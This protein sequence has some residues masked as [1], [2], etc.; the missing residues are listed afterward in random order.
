MTIYEYIGYTKQDIEQIILNLPR[1]YIT[2]KILK[3]SGKMRRIDAPQNPLKNIQKEIL[4][5]VLYLYK[6]HP[7]AHGFVKDKSP[8]TNA[9]AHVGRKYVLSIDI[10]NF[11]NSISEQTVQ[12]CLIW[13]FKQQTKFTWNID[14]CSIFAKLLCYNGGLPQGSPASPVMSNLVCLALDK[15]LAALAAAN[16][17]TITRYADDITLSSNDE[18]VLH[19]SRD[20]YFLIIS[21]GMRPNKAKTKF[22]RYFQRQQVTGIV[23]NQQLG[24]KKEVW[25]NLRAQ[26]HN[27][28]K[29]STSITALEYQQMR[30]LIE[31]IRSLNQHRGQQ[32]LNQLFLINVKP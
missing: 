4:K 16:D 13:L 6:A 18:K 7:I 28:Q 27:L 8:I 17:V 22:R 30:G 15:K 1:F 23:V 32:L 25:R 11:F 12:R 14:D 24:T 2:Y 31:W 29:D 5:K 19:I 3:R 21:Y 26:L 9:S 20:I 10:K